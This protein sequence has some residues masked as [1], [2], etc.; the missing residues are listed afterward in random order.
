M[1]GLDT[2]LTAGLAAAASSHVA[3]PM[4]EMELLLNKSF[5]ALF[6]AKLEELRRLK[7]LLIDEED[8]MQVKTLPAAAAP[9]DFKPLLELVLPRIMGFEMTRRTSAEDAFPFNAP[10]FDRIR[11][12]EEIT[13]W[14]IL[15]WYLSFRNGAAL[16]ER[17]DGSREELLRLRCVENGKVKFMGDK[18]MDS[19][20][21]E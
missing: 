16:L 11:D 6:E 10:L 15:I 12:D 7:S 5:L 13:R 2:D 9:V 18:K 21:Q 4:L 8:I 3:F 14:F 20:F 19:D 1:N 17:L